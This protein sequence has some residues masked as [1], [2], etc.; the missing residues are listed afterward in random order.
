MN[1]LREVNQLQTTKGLGFV[2]I[3]SDELIFCYNNLNFIML[4]YIAYYLTI[5]S[6]I[7]LKPLTQKIQISKQAQT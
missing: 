5:L 4:F 7:I 1:V 3:G 6:S 2:L